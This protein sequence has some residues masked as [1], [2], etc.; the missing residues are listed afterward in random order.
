MG[1]LKSFFFLYPEYEP[2]FFQN[3]ITAFFWVKAITQKNF[4]KDLFISFR[5]LI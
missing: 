3:V 2:D 4:Q 5:E 1:T